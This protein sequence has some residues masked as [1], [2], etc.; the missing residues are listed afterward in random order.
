[1]DIANKREDG[2]QTAEILKDMKKRTS[3][4]SGQ[5]KKKCWKA[6]LTHTF[7]IKSLNKK[8]RLL[9]KIKALFVLIVS[10]AE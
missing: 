4:K 7:G 9:F 6:R 3:A 1:M 5:F 10:I 2:V 8:N